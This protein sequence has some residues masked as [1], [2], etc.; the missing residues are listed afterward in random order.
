MSKL[1]EIADAERKAEL[2]RNTYQPNK[3]FDMSADATDGF[4]VDKTERER[5]LARNTYSKNNQYGLDKI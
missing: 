1:T 5:Q 3:S 2:A 4:P